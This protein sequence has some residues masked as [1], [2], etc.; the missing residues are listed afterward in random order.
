M[1]KKTN[2]VFSRDFFLRDTHTV[3]QEVLGKYLVRRRGRGVVDAMITEVEVYD[4][5][6]DRASHASRGETARNAIMFADGGRW[7]VYLCYG[8]HWMLN[9]TTREAGYPAAILIR[10]VEGISGPG[11]L[12]RRFGIDKRVHELPIE[13]ASGVWIEDRDGAT[14]SR[15]IQK[16]PRIGVDYA[17][18]HWARKHWRYVLKG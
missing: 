13:P 4:G 8:I 14:S 7:Y 11:R 16:T 6:N 12:T 18:E 1:P 5:F 15:H 3:A 17:G 2:T 9:I 10:G